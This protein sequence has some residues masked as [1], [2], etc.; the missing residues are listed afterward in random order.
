L[1]TALVLVELHVAARI[2]EC[3]NILKMGKMKVLEFSRE[4]GILV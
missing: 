2:L 1:Y 4:E 3:M